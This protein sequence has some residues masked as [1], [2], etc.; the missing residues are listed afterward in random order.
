[1]LTVSPGTDCEFSV[2]RGGHC[3]AATGCGPPPDQPAPGRG[4]PRAHG[5]DRPVRRTGCV[6][7]GS[8]GFSDRYPILERAVA[9]APLL[10]EPSFAET[11]RSL[12]Q[13]ILDGSENLGER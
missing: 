3:P 12:V 5:R 7:R 8:D 11:V 9:E 13:R 2:A 4:L 1:M 10:S 6:G